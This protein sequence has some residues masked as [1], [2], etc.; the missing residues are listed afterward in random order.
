MKWIASAIILGLLPFATSAAEFS[1]AAQI[2]AAESAFA[3]HSVATDMREAFLAAFAE[4]STLLR[5]GPVPARETIR[6]NPAPPIELNW[7]P[8]FVYAAASGDIG[9]ST[10]PWRI[11]SKND[12][13]APAKFGQFVSVWKRQADGVWK[14]FI[15]MGISHPG[16]WLADAWLT[17]SGAIQPS[18][19]E[20]AAKNAEKTF[21]EISEKSGYLAALQR[22]GALDARVYRD[23][24]APFLGPDGIGKVPDGYAGSGQEIVSSGL[25]R[26]GDMAFALV[27]I[28]LRKSDGSLDKPTAHALHIWKAASDGKLE[29][30]LDV[31]N[32]MPKQ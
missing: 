18:V 17:L 13:S 6:K 29:L 27:R 1:A 25:S 9:Y 24:Y 28:A 30:V 7:R 3:A 4:D 32:E 15:D 11:T 16:P 8:A 21:S 26:A 19:D 23:G 20:A 14:V 22:F 5:S 2:A 12:P 10:G 31:V